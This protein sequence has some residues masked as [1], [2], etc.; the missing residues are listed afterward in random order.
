MVNA[1]R[2]VVYLEGSEVTA[3]AFALRGLSPGVFARSGSI[4]VEMVRAMSI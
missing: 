2:A 3:V 4:A 1:G